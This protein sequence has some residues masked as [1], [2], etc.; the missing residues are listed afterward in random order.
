MVGTYRKYAPGLEVDTLALASHSPDATEARIP[1]MRGGDRHHGS[2]HP[3]NWG[4]ARPTE[5][6]PGYRTPVDGLYLCG[7]SQHP[8]GS[9]HGQPGFNAAGTVAED[10]GV[11]PWWKKSNPLDVLAAID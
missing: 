4:Y 8:G 3:S 2:F 1:S 7:A 5:H 9:F 11:T 6:M 10:L